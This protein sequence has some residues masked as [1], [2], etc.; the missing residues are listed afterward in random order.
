MALEELTSYIDVATDLLVKGRKIGQGLHLLPEAPLA[1]AFVQKAMKP[2]HRP[3]EGGKLM[4]LAGLE[5]R[6]FL[7]DA[8]E[9]IV[10]RRKGDLTGEILL[11]ERLPVLCNISLELLHDLGRSRRLG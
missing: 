10:H 11:L 8:V 2:P 6:A 4:K 1:E 7:L 5:N 3:G 9:K